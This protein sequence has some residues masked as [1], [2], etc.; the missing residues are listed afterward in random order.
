MKKDKQIKSD[1]W[2]I[3]YKALPKT[4][5]KKL[6]TIKKTVFKFKKPNLS[7]IH[8][9]LFSSLLIAGTAAF[10]SIFGL[11]ALFAGAYYSVIFMAGSLELGKLV[12][13]SLLYR[14]WESFNILFRSY[15]LTAVLTL[16]VIT[17]IGI[18]GYLS[19]AYQKSSL[20]LNKYMQTKE[21][22]EEQI[23]TLTQDRTYLKKELAQVVESYPENYITA[24]R[25]AREQYN[26]QI[27]GVSKS[28]NQLKER[29][30][31][32]DSQLLDT[33]IDVGPIVFVARTLDL[34]ID[35][36][37]NLLILILICVFD[38]LAVMLIIG[39]T[40]LMMEKNEQEENKKEDE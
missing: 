5:A 19:A 38:P 40:K 39:Y 13:A 4:V 30:Y 27:Q 29:L 32:I 15:Y 17:S 7:F 1:R 37:V 33:N 22:V 25:Q 9:V 6:E 10:F 20:E 2:E 34:D 31:N 36:T 3:N 18:Y 23:S 12:T 14:K 16:V 26:P 21:F 24:K 11:S 8:L 35:Y 28:I